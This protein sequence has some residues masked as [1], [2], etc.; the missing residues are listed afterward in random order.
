MFNWWVRKY[1]QFYAENVCLS[2]PM[3]NEY[4]KSVNQFGSRS[5]PI[6]W[7]AWS[8]F[9]LLSADTKVVTSEGMVLG[10]FSHRHLGL[11][12]FGLDISATNVSATENVEGGRFGHNHKF[13]VW[14]V[15]MHKFVIHFIIFWNQKCMWI[16]TVDSK[17]HDNKSMLFFIER[18]K[19][20][21]ILYSSKWLWNTCI[22]YTHYLN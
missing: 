2:K 9:K 8:G 3:Y 18:G 20:W 13:W 4:Y 16:L 12:R 22:K 11:G 14:D 1:L 10:H 19:L 7:Q 5:G 21:Y 6:L 17:M 15:C